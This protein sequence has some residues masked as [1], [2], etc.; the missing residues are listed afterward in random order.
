MKK[1]YICPAIRAVQIESSGTG[2]DGLMAASLK[3]N[4]NDAGQGNADTEWG[5]KEHS[6]AIGGEEGSE[7][8]LW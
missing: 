2:C 1:K 8:D 4:L 3:I 5:A 6:G 7:D